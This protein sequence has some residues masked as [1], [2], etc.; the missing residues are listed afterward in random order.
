VH[1]PTLTTSNYPPGWLFGSLAVFHCLSAAGLSL[2]F[3]TAV[4][5]F[6][7]SEHSQ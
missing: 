1:I 3:Q 7:Q 5:T 2:F 6:N 4:F